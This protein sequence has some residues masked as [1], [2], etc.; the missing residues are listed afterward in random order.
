MALSYFFK[1]YWIGFPVI[2]HLDLFNSILAA[3]YARQILFTFLFNFLVINP[4]TE[5]W[6]CIKVG[7]FKWI[8]TINGNPET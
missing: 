7:I 5:F 2:I 3:W 6:S 1:L 4:G 8:P